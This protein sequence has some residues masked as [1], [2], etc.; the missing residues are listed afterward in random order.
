MVPPGATSSSHTNAS[1]PKAAGHHPSRAGNGRTPSAGS[2]RAARQ[3]RAWAL[4]IGLSLLQVAGPNSRDRG[5]NPTQSRTYTTHA[6]GLS[7]YSRPKN[8]ASSV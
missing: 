1:S 4:R 6:T 5:T 8:S 2:N 7:A 3:I